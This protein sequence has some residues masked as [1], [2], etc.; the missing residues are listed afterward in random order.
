MP[1]DEYIIDQVLNFRFNKGK[2]EFQ[3]SWEDY[4]IEEATWEPLSSLYKQVSLLID[5]YLEPLNKRVVCLG[6]DTYILEDVKPKKPKNSKIT[7]LLQPKVP[8]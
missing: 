2:Y 5:Q 6:E 8:S 7:S 1:G 4:D 3:V